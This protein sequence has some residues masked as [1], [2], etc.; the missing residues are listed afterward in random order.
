M[1]SRAYSYILL[2]GSMHGITLLASR[3]S[4]GQYATSNYLFLR[5]VIAGA[6]YA[7]IMLFRKQERVPLDKKLW[8]HGIIIGLLQSYTMHAIILA[9]LYI[10]SGVNSILMSF[11]PAATILMAHFFLDGE[12]LNFNKILGV[13]LAL[14]GVATIVVSGETGLGE[15]VDGK[16][17]GYFLC[18][19]G[20]IISSVNS[21]Y[22]RKYTQKYRTIHLTAIRNL[23]ILTVTLVEVL[24]IDGFDVSK[25]NE[26]GWLALA[27][28]AVIGTFLA[29][30]LQVMVNKNYG[31]T[32]SAMITF[33][34]P[35]VANIGG[36][37]LFGERITLVSITGMLVI[38]LGIGLI[39]RKPVAGKRIP[40]LIS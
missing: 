7:L 14:A 17:M 9:M 21:I 1:K 38:F 3:F 15:V 37:I 4:T 18:L 30:M 12:K 11:G 35:V 29:H 13:L 40:R 26:Q 10:S 34:I 5:F 31:A 24:F 8:M 16:F 39:N 33:V 32:I 19:S 6:L 22:I 25:V 2:I 23:V 36:V 20:V 27:F 28:A